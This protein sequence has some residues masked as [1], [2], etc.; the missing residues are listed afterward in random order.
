MLMAGEVERALHD[1][2]CDMELVLAGAPA[3]LDRYIGYFEPYATSHDALDRDEAFMEEAKN[4]ARTLMQAVTETR[5]GRWR[6]PEGIKEPR[7]K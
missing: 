4:A 1:W 7:P 3:L 5:R 6:I 2:L